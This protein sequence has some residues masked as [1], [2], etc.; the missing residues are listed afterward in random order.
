MA[1]NI[2]VLSGNITLPNGAAY[3]IYTV[4]AGRTAKVVVS[5]FLFNGH[6]RIGS[7]DTSV[8]SMP[9]A[10]L[11]YPYLNGVS[12]PHIYAAGYSTAFALPESFFIAPGEVITFAPNGAGMPLRYSMSVVEE[13]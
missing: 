5:H 11:Q 6:L 8:L 9:S 13:Y 12:M 1:K 2:L 4:P 10:L 7:F 3:T